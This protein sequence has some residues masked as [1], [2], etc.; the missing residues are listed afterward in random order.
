MSSNTLSRGPSINTETCVSNMGGR[1]DLIVA[2]SIR[3]REI[4]RQTRE[5]VPYVNP[6]ITALKEVESGEVGREYLHKVR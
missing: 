2:A 1:F 3:A 5:N 4:G 6:V